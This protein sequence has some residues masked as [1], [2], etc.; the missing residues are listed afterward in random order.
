MHGLYKVNTMA[1]QNAVSRHLKI[2]ARIDLD[3]TGVKHFELPEDAVFLLRSDKAVL[4][5]TADF[6]KIERN[7]EAIEDL[8]SIVYNFI[9]YSESK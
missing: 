2:K 3:E 1:F 4:E 5:N 7:I 6:V 8:I 9:D